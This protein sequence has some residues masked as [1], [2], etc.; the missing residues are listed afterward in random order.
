MIEKSISSAINLKRVQITDDFW[1]KE[2][3]LVRDTVIPY[4]WEVLNDRVPGVQRSYCM[5]NFEVV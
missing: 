2:I 1:K 5:H 4:Q 3:R